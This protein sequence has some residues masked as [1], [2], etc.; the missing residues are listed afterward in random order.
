MLG[1]HAIEENSF[2]TE[3]NENP[4]NDFEQPAAG[5]AAAPQTGPSST[6]ANTQVNAAGAAAQTPAQPATPPAPGPVSQANP[7]YTAGQPAP[8]AQQPIY[9]QAAAQPGA[10]P[11]QQKRKVWPWILLA[12]LL[13]FLLGLGG[14]AGCTAVG[15][16]LGSNPDARSGSLHQYDY[17]DIPYG[18]DSGSNSNSGSSS[19][20]SD[21]YGG[22]TMSDIQNAAEGLSG[23][24]EDGKAASGMY[25]V[26]RD[27][28][29]GSYFMQG[30]TNEESNFYIFTPE[31]SGTYSL[32]ASIVYVGHYFY[33]LEDGQ[34]IVFIPAG[35]DLRMIP[36][37]QADFNPSAPYSSGL[38]RVGTD[39][40]AGTYTVSVSND[41]PASSTQEYAAYVMQD[42]EFNDDSILET[43]YLLKGQSQSITVEEGQL[44]ELFGCTA[45]PTD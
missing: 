10:A 34:I 21:I 11:T 12:C 5:A 17:D 16:L 27:I 39:I 22:F 26:G 45:T 36:T 13:A 9:N 7:V 19:S 31:G 24:I 28:D 14:C 37:D 42:L 2:M 44:L 15:L 3:P 32:K 38:Y 8:A 35:Q 6:D 23:D 29:A 18:Y 20:S 30:K 43:K 25:V 4:A 41:A 1:K 33:D 40:P